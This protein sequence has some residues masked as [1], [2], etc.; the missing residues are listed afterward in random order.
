[1]LAGGANNQLS[2]PPSISMTEVPLNKA[3]NPQ[4]TVRKTRPPLVTVA[5]TD[6]QCCSHTTH[7]LTQWKTHHRAKKKRTTHR[8]R[9]QS[10]LLLIWNKISGPSAFKQCH[11]LTNSNNKY[12][13]NRS[14]MCPDRS[15][16][17]L[18]S[19]QNGSSFQIYLKHEMNM[20]KHQKV[21]YFNTI[22]QV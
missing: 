20:N 4:L 7:V 6:K 19:N 16:Y 10:R 15:L 21:F 13:F 5:M 2:L 22:F 17:C 1:M 18:S 12:N 14:S 3:P 8:Q 9:R 11:F